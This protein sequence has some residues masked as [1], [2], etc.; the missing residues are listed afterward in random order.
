MESLA[1]LR[2]RIRLGLVGAICAWTGWLSLP[3]A[4][5]ERCPPGDPAQQQEAMTSL[6][7]RIEAWDEAYYGQ[8]E[9]L[10]EDSVYD[11]TRERLIAWQ[12][13]LGSPTPSP[14]ARR[15]AHLAPIR[16]SV[17][18]AIVQTGL[19]KITDPDALAVWVKRR[20]SQGLWVQPKVDGVAVTLVY[21]DGQL[22]E[23][24]SR[25]DGRQ[26]QDWSGHAERIEAIPKTLAG[27]APPPRVTLQ[28][29][30]YHRRA[31]HVQADM[32][33]DGARSTIIGLMARH[34]LDAK[35]AREIGLFVWDWPDGPASMTDRLDG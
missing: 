33:S 32:G 6:A 17:N 34:T 18:H 31:G 22:L 13:C 20:Q 7:D 28:G 29:E 16:D 19:D 8:G 11:Q 10:V 30:L 2:S 25:G 3:L 35:D 9:R 23:V 4:W 21:D 14:A 27:T 26:G 1:T 12:A 15:E 24:V 5:A